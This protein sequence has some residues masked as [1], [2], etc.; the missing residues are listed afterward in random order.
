MNA[1]K[2]AARAAGLSYLLDKVVHAFDPLL[3]PAVDW[4]RDRF[5]T[6]RNW[7]VRR[8]GRSKPGPVPEVMSVAEFDGDGPSDV[9][10]VP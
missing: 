4:V 3:D 9:L 10:L 8:F 7:L 5:T 1:T 2:T 6:F